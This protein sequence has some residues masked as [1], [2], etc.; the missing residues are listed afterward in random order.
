MAEM[1]EVKADESLVAFCGLYCGACRGFLKGKCPGCAKNEKAS[2]CK[3][4][5]CCREG[6]FSSCADC[7]DFND[8]MECK[9]F[10]NFISKLFA[11]IF[12]SNRAACIGQIRKCGIRCH[13]EKMAELKQMSLKR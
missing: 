8:P 13:A 5:T 6:K 12:K 10:N 4:R 11:L 3:I 1:K 9:K 2:W 7:K